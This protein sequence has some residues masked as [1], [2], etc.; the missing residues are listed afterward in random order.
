MKR[1]ILF[2]LMTAMILSLTGCAETPDAPAVAQKNNERLESAAAE[3]D[4]NRRPLSEIK[5][6]LTG[7][8]GTPAAQK[9]TFRFGSEDGKVKIAADADVFLPGSDRIP[10]YHLACTGFTQEQA[11]AMF[12]CLMGGRKAWRVEGQ[13]ASKSDVDALLLEL[14]QKVAELEADTAYTDKEVH[15]AEIASYKEKIEELEAQYD[16]FPDEVKKIPVDGTYILDEGRQR[17]YIRAQTDDGAQFYLSD[18]EEELDGQTSLHYYTVSGARYEEYYRSN[19]DITLCSAAEAGELCK[20]AYTYEEALAL[21]QGLPQA[22]GVNVRLAEFGLIKGADAEEGTGLKVDPDYTGYVFF[23]TRLIDNV[24]VA[25][26]T[27]EYIYH[28][29]TAPVWLYEKIMVIVNDDGIAYAD[30]GFPTELVDTVSGDV[31]VIPFEKAAA[32]FEQMEPLIAQG[33]VS[34]DEE[35]S[36]SESSYDISV[37]RVELN[38]IRVRDSGDLTGLYAPAWVFYGKESHYIKDAERVTEGEIRHAPWIVM[39]VNA[40][41]GSVID[42]IAGY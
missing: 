2:L 39:A 29:D 14:K 19:Q 27:S 16:T 18:A 1:S 26:T 3:T 20:C 10:M 36:Q 6:S 34:A 41:D 5:E 7:A 32:I 23:F 15:D 28:E 30:W 38:L 12:D 8:D 17:R 33:N 4:E 21:A 40:V 37:D 25:A 9:Y 31:S 35:N 42:I 22:A 24:P 13:S 11:K